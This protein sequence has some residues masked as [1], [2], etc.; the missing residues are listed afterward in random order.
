MTQLHA[1]E[2]LLKTQKGVG[3]QVRMRMG[4]NIPS[5]PRAYAV[6]AAKLLGTTE[7]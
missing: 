6:H 7:A 2:G 5:R 1:N 4:R 3:Y